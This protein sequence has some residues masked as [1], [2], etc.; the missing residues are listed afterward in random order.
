MHGTFFWTRWVPR[1]SISQPDA[2]SKLATRVKVNLHEFTGS[3][4]Q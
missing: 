2:V 3:R 4:S 1:R